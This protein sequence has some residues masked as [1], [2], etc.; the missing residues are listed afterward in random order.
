MPGFRVDGRLAYTVCINSICMSPSLFI[1]PAAPTLNQTPVGLSLE[2]DT[3]E[4]RLL[5]LRISAGFP[6]PA[7]DYV[8]EG[9]DLNAYNPTT[10]LSDFHERKFMA[11]TQGAVISTMISLR[12]NMGSVQGGS[13]LE[14]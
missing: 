5:A 1:P 14:S 12:L 9:L 2:P 13:Y 8:E 3:L 4:L 7:A 11:H 10:Y 6:S